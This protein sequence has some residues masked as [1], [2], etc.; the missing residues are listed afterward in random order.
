MEPGKTLADSKFYIAIDNLDDNDRNVAEIINSI[1]WSCFG[2]FISSFMDRSSAGDNES[3]VCYDE[4]KG[5]V[6]FYFS[7]YEDTSGE[8]ECYGSLSYNETIELFYKYF[9]AFKTFVETHF[10]PAY[11]KSEWYNR[12]IPALSRLNAKWKELASSD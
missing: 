6:L 2:N 11:R 10:F 3:E 7:C 5:M 9:N 12:F 4:K 8:I 1:S